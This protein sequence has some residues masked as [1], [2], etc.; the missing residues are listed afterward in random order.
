MGNTED[1]SPLP[2]S[3]VA[4]NVMNATQRCMELFDRLD[5]AEQVWSMT[6]H[7][8]PNHGLPSSRYTGNIEPRDATDECTEA[9]LEV[10]AAI[11]EEDSNIPNKEER[12]VEYTEPIAGKT[13]AQSSRSSGSSSFVR[14]SDSENDD[15]ESLP[16]DPQF[17]IKNSITRLYN[18]SSAIRKTGNEYRDLH[19]EQ[20][21]E[22]VRYP[23]TDHG[24]EEI[25]L[26]LTEIFMNYASG[27]ILKK[28]PQREERR[29]IAEEWLQHRL[30]RT[31]AKRRN[32]LLYRRKHQETLRKVP[33]SIRPSIPVDDPKVYRPEQHSTYSTLPK[34]QIVAESTIFTD[35]NATHVTNASKIDT[36]AFHR[37]DS[38]EALSNVSVSTTRTFITTAN[39]DVKFRSS[40]A[41]KAF[42]THFTCPLVFFP[43]KVSERDPK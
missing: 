21:V 41:T 38:F 36:K 9:N 39:A 7:A 35:T 11:P 2:P 40:P 22:R 20:Y 34:P 23:A 12:E 16:Y 15:D 29:A 17:A 43:C 42:D 33:K 1:G 5:V 18:L 32:I 13:D 25:T 27:I 30:A 8:R 6:Q 37:F 24:W 26:N 4:K 3:T 14:A 28:L 10:V 31:I 19:A